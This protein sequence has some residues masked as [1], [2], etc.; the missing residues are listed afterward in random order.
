MYKENFKI[1]KIYVWTDDGIIKCI[2]KRI[3]DGDYKEDFERF[4]GISINPH[5]CR[6]GHS[7]GLFFTKRTIRSATPEEEYWLEKCIEADKF[8]SK[9]S[10]KEF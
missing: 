2:V 8:I 7:K 6:Y 5:E 9:K 10:F 4:D 3:E 1:G